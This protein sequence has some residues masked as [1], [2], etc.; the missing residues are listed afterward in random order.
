M[1]RSEAG[2]LNSWGL[3]RAQLC[4]NPHF[5]MFPSLPLGCPSCCLY[6]LRLHA[7]PQPHCPQK[8]MS[9]GKNTHLG[10]APKVPPTLPA[11]LGAPSPSFPSISP[12][13]NNI[14][15]HPGNLPMDLRTAPP[16][17]VPFNVILCYRNTRA[18]NPKPKQT[19]GHLRGPVTPT[20][21]RISIA[22]L[23]SCLKKS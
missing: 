16:P 14:P 23:L 11:P 2:C 8:D 19:A 5:P 22:S 20:H 17:S 13:A 3:Y 9:E 7:D 21:L 18:A 6:Q 10:T 4:L 12:D 15:T 1:E